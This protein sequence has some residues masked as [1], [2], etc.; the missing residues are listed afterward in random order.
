MLRVIALLHHPKSH[1]PQLLD[2]HLG[3]HVNLSSPS[4]MVSHPGCEAKKQAQTMTL[5]VLYST[6]M[7]LLSCAVV[8]TICSAEYSTLRIIPESIFY[9]TVGIAKAAPLP[10]LCLVKC[11]IM[12]LFC[13]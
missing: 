9:N 8:F 11:I 3:K 2:S 6:V 1:K 5:P 13:M 10:L 4:T 12:L 7:M